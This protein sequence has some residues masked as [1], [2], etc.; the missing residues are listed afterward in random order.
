MK[1]QILLEAVSSANEINEIPATLT[2][3]KKRAETNI[4]EQEAERK[5]LSQELHDNVNQLVATAKLFVDRLQ[6][7]NA[8]HEE[9]RTKISQY[10]DMAFTEIR[11]L[12][13]SMAAPHFEKSKLTDS[14]KKIVSDIKLAGGFTVLSDFDERVE[15]L[16]SSKKMNLFRIFQEQ[17]KNTMR[18]SKATLIQTRLFLIKNTVHM[19]IEDNG[20]GFD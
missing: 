2:L 9:F 4:T 8:Q 15:M 3:Q 20:V 17:I 1:N 12:S 11:S 5:R 18:Y 13:H 10:L 7:K 16:D 19:I 6:T 14:L